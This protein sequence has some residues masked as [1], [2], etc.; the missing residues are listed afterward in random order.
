MR[1]G[2]CCESIIL[3]LELCC[4]HSKYSKYQNISKN[5]IVIIK[6]LTEVV[7]CT[8]QYPGGCYKY[9]K[10]PDASKN[11]G[12][13]NFSVLEGVVSSTCWMARVWSC[14]GI[15]EQS[16]YTGGSHGASGGSILRQ[17]WLDRLRVSGAC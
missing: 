15:L 1:N 14:Q 7:L 9:F 16:G 12:V 2:G 6:V 17:G 11:G 8:F 4:G 5:G 10:R 3:Y 13:Y